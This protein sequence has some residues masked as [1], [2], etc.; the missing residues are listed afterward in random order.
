MYGFDRNSDKH[1]KFDDTWMENPINRG[2]LAVQPSLRCSENPTKKNAGKT[3]K[4]LLEKPQIEQLLQYGNGELNRCRMGTE[5]TVGGWTKTKAHCCDTGTSL[6][7]M[8]PTL[9]YSSVAR[10]RRKHEIFSLNFNT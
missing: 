1:A 6:T 10:V 9:D 5:S 7:D 3:A 2:N 4:P 8:Q